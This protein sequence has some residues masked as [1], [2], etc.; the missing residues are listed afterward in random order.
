[1]WQFDSGSWE[2]SGVWLIVNT[3]SRVQENSYPNSAG[4]W[5][6]V[7][8]VLYSKHASFMPQ[9]LVVRSWYEYIWIRVGQAS[10]LYVI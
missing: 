6:R 8:T 2:R 1:M 4:V 7:G 3:V 5:F 10:A 9:R